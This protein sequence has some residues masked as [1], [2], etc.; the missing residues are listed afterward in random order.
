MPEAHAPGVPFSGLAE[1]LWVRLARVPDAA[2]EARALPES[3]GAD[4]ATC[5]KKR[6]REIP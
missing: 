2:R 4:V 5:L 1:K 6:K 3:G